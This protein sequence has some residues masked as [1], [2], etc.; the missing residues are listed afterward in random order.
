MNQT[1]Q[2]DDSQAA[3]QRVLKVKKVH[4]S[5]LMSKPDVVGVGV[6]KSG[7]D[8]VLVV[9]V[10]KISSRPLHPEERIPDEIEGVKVEIRQ[11]GQPG[12]QQ[13]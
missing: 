7:D 2:P 6:G 11:I 3:Y 10:K 12:A 9:L 4:E 1:F 5:R 8:F 13:N